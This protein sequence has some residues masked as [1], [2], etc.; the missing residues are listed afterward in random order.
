MKAAIPLF[1][2][3]V[4]P[5]FDCG[6]VVLL[7]QVDDGTVMSTEQ[8]TDAAGNSLERIA[9]LRELGVDTVVCGAITGFLLRHLAANGIRVFPWVFCE[10]SEALEAL[11]RGELSATLPRAVGRGPGRTRGR[12][13]MGRGGPRWSR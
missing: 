7:A 2:T 6:G 10:A 8:V 13:G 3:R 9:R 4:S 11:A 5:R 12:R 1:G